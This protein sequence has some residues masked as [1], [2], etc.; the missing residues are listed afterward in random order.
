MA[1]GLVEVELEDDGASPSRVRAPRASRRP[2]S[3]RAWSRWALVTA[4]VL[5]AGAGLDGS[6]AAGLLAAPG[7]GL[8]ADLRADRRVQWRAGA[9]EVLGT[10]GGT[11]LVVTAD[12]GT[13]MA[14]DLADGRV[15]WSLPVAGC[16]LA[17]TSRDDGR[18]RGAVAPADARLLCEDMPSTQTTIVT[19]ADAADGTVLASFA[20]G[21]ESPQ[22]SAAGRVAVVLTTIATGSST[23]SVYS[24]RTGEHLW[25]APVDGDARGRWYVDGDALV[26]LDPPRA[27]DLDTGE[28][29]DVPGPL[30]ETS[31]PMADGSLVRATV[32]DVGAVG[33]VPTVDVLEPAG[34]AGATAGAGG[35]VR[36]SAR[37]VPLDPPGPPGTVVVL[38]TSPGAMEVHDLADGTVLWRDARPPA[39]LG[40]AGGVLVAV[41]VDLAAGTAGTDST[42]GA[43]START[44][45]AGSG[46]ALLG[47]DARTGRELWRLPTASPGPLVTDGRRFALTTATGVEARDLRSGEV[48]ATWRVP[49]AT[50]GGARAGVAGAG[51]TP[52]TLS[53]LPEGRLAWLHDNQVAV[54]GF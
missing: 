53:V 16:R 44:A 18:P 35:T 22:V 52:P 43:D 30:S 9:S 8:V 54:L 23:L 50:G 6:V 37:G 39:L 5:A 10:V 42:A 38:W 46:L 49:D 51:P 4:L 11:V 45:D 33:A 34:S 14:R 31:G 20:D 3:T 15:R 29:V 12:G 2:W 40:E 32:T 25:G 19:L 27:R 24:L 13:V 28:A 47:L 7:P 26:L 1:D 17:D 48:S 21:R 41:D 36:W